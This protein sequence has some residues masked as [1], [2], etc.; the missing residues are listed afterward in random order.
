MRYHVRSLLA[1][2]ALVALDL[3]NH[4]ALGYFDPLAFAIVMFSFAIALVASV[5]PDVARGPA[6]AEVDGDLLVVG[7]TAVGL[8][9]FG[10]SSVHLTFPERFWALDAVRWCAAGGFVVCLGGLF[11]RRARELFGPIDWNDVRAHHRWILAGSVLGLLVIVARVEFELALPGWETPAAFLALY[12]FG[13][14]LF[15]RR[16][17]LF[18]RESPADRPN[19]A[20][21]FGAALALGLVMRG[22]MLVAAPDPVIDVFALMRDGTD[23]LIA[24]R[25]LYA[26]D[27]VSPYGTPRAHAYHNDEPPDPRP[28]GYPPHPY[29]ITAAFRAAKLDPRWADVACDLV[30]AAALFVVAWRRG[31]PRAGFL[32][33]VAFLFLPRTSVMIESAWYE[34][35]IA[36]LLGVGLWLIEATGAWRWRFVVLGLALT[37]KQYGLPLLPAAA[38]PHRRDCRPLLIGLGAGALVMWP[39]FLWSPHDFMDTVLWKHLDRPSQHGR[40]MTIAAACYDAT[41]LVPQR[42]VLWA[43]AAVLI[44]VVS[45]RSNRPGAASALGIGTALFIFCLFHTQGFFN[46]FHLIQYLLLLGAVGLLPKNDPLEARPAGSSGNRILTS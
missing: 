1:L 18:R 20:A 25:N 29:L 23:H 46:Y 22:L 16:R 39:W 15:L 8:T 45:W 7:L 28:A 37:A 34:P 2:A 43:I 36:A 38:W 17:E 9:G 30:A 35:M 27:I 12:A 10:I 33:A 5:M 44:A 32:A 24:G 42:K 6:D 3:A 19:M 41:G 4:D 26:E 13:T 14:F 11:W 21:W 31:R 40:A